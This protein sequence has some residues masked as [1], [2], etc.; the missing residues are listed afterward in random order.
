MTTYVEPTFS[1]FDRALA[2][3]YTRGRGSYPTAL[4]EAIF[5][6]HAQAWE[7]TFGTLLDVGCGPGSA[8]RDAAVTFKHAIGIDPAVEMINEARRLGGKT[9]SG[10]DIRFEVCAAERLMECPGVEGGSVDVIIA[11]MAV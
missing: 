9:Y 11:A 1:A 3:A 4:Y 2:I 6:F 10:E 5:E 7:N 8:V